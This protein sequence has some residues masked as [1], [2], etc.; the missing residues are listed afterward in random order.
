VGNISIRKEGSTKTSV[1]V[2]GE[3]VE[4][5]KAVSAAEV[6]AVG[7][8][9]AEVWPGVET[10]SISCDVIFTLDK[11][12]VLSDKTVP[13]K[14]KIETLK[15]VDKSALIQALSVSTVISAVT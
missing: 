3:D 10:E 9:A 14:D 6:A 15:S 2:V 13:L 11:V 8:G 4:D 1:L 7:L 5:C 12:A